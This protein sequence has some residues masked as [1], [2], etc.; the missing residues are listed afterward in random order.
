MERETASLG[1]VLQVQACSV[2]QSRLGRVR[3]HPRST[4]VACIVLHLGGGATI[5]LSV[6]IGFLALAFVL[7]VQAC[8]VLQSG[9]SIQ[10]A[11]G[12]VCPATSKVVAAMPLS[13]QK[14]A[15]ALPRRMLYDC[16]ST[17]DQPSICTAAAKSLSWLPLKQGRCA[18]RAP[19]LC[20]AWKPR[21]QAVGP[22]A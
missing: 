12:K 6:G 5:H 3:H 19:C 9:I 13:W 10:F 2:L 18:F 22:Q 1:F 20:T 11:G 16:R 21:P 7:H 14:C 4:L 15:V 17:L 8:S